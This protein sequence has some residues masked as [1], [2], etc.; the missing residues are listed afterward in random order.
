MRV[1][2]AIDLVRDARFVAVTS[3]LPPA[4]VLT[5][6]LGTRLAPLTNVRAKPAVPVAGVPL[7]VRQ[8]RWLAEQGVPAAVLNLHHRPHTITRDVG[9]GT[10]IGIRVRYSW[11]PIVLGTAGG[12]RRALPLLGHRF[13][14]VNGDTLADVDLG[15]LLRAHETSQADVTLAVTPNPAPLRYGGAVVDEQGW[16]TSFTGPGPGTHLH[17]VGVQVVEGS[18]FADL[19]DGVPAASI[20]GVYN[21]RLKNHRP[22]LR[23]HAVMAPFY[24]IGTPSDYL[25]TTL[26]IAAAEGLAS[27]VPGA[28][29][30]I[31]PSASVERTAIWD[32]V[33][34]GDGCRLVD[35]IVADGVR[36][37]PNTVCERGIITRV[38]DRGQSPGRALA[39]VW[40]SPLDPSAA[41]T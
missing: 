24:D 26:A 32:D 35:S 25:A 10:E 9:Y 37:P 18:I 29:C 34:I 31:D 3:P 1:R 6:G 40:I 33:V 20:G 2:T 30:T 7:I 11:E 41:R 19:A 17:F 21:Q 15:R 16:V 13:F 39:D 23:V 4:L 28:R 36:V 14:I 12:P 27:P 5:A 22:R 8:L 38:Q